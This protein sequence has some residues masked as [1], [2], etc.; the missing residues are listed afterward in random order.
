MYQNVSNLVHSLLSYP[1]YAEIPGPN[2]IHLMTKMSLMASYLGG[3]MPAGGPE[4]KNAHW[5][6]FISDIVCISQNY[7]ILR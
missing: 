1:S 7:A 6:A 3:C 4:F 5:N 2:L